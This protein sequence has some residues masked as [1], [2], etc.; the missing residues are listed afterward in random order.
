MERELGGEDHKITTLLFVPVTIRNAL[1]DHKYHKLHKG[2][3][4]YNLL[5]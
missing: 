1:T 5:K 3:E 4:A 2:L